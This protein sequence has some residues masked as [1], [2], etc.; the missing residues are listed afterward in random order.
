VLSQRLYDDGLLCRLDDRGDPVVQL[1]PPLI[2]DEELLGRIVD[3]VG[4]AVEY[5]WGEVQKGM[6]TD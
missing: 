2:A 6:P 3:I 1:S 5:A 4:E